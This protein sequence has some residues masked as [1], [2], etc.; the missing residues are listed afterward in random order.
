MANRERLMA[1]AATVALLMA[2]ATPV[3]A[4][5]QPSAQPSGGEDHGARAVLDEVVVTAQRRE[6]GLSKVPIAVS[7]YSGEALERQGVTN[8]DA[9]SQVS[10]S[11][12][13]QNNQSSAGAGVRVRGIGTAVFNAGSEQSVTTVID[14]VITGPLGS[15]LADLFDVERVE[16]LRGPQGTLFGKNSSA[17]AVNVVTRRP[18][19]QFSGYGVARYGERLDEYRV[20]GAVSGTVAEG[21]RARLAGFKLTQNEGAYANPARGE[22]EDTRDRWGLR[23]RADYT[24]GP[25]TADLSL[26]REERDDACC[27]RLF[28]GV[29]PAAYGTLTKLYLLPRLAAYGVKPT[30]DN[31]ISISN[32]VST[33]TNRTTHGALTMSYE[34]ANGATIRSISGHRRWIQSERNDADRID[35]DIGDDAF[36]SRDL[37]IWS[38]ELQLISPADQRL[39]YVLGAYYYKQSLDEFTRTAGGSQSIFGYGVTTIPLRVEVENKAI[40]GHATYNVTDQWQAFGGLRLLEEEISAVGVRSGNYFAL[41]GTF[42]GQASTTDKNWVGTMG[43]RYEVSPNVSYYGSVSRGYKGAAIDVALGS[44]FFTGKPSDAILNPETVVSYELGVKARLN[45]G[46]LRVNGTLFNSD[47]K[48]FQ[49]SQFDAATTSFVLRNAG[50]VRTRGAEVDFQALVTDSLMV[51][52]G[53]AYVDAVFAEYTG[54]PCTVP[55]QAAGT[56]SPARGGQNLTGQRVN[57]NPKWQY[58]IAAEQT[59]HLPNGME[60]YLRGDYGWR[61]DIIF[62]GDLNPDTTQPAYGVANFRSGLVFNTNYEVA[63]FVQNAFDKIYANRISDALFYPGAY[64]GYFGPRRTWGLELRASF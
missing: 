2:A 47:F 11:V 60:A 37:N 30:A 36:Q 51:T 44:S 38:Q 8:V 5:T 27:T 6:Q 19:D 57:A 26:T 16:V 22:R 63:V 43:V 40:F 28:V 45:E 20:E 39:T 35:I 25:F 52:G 50:K 54:A 32:G 24:R 15:G 41:P 46:R 4:Q 33:E 42:S 12:T 7:A 49:S 55:Q 17:G 58:N 56:C 9:L 59:F 29:N 10:P 23:L 53:V 48:D 21:L 1:A 31:Q 18:T 14:G 34:L 61:S 64:Q 3:L 62:G 13:F